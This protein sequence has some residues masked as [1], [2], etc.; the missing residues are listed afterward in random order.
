MAESCTQ[1]S[2]SLLIHI[3]HYTAFFFVYKYPRFLSRILT[4]LVSKMAYHEGKGGVDMDPRKLYVYALD[5][6]TKIVRQV[7]AEQMDLPTPD[8]EWTVHDLLQHITYELAWTADIVAGK[9][10]A[11]VGDKYEGELL[12]GNVLD[13]WEHYEAITRTAVE[14]CD[15]HGIAHL[16]YSDKTISEYLLEA[17]NDQLIH[18]WDLGQAIGVSVDFDEQ[19]AQTLYEQALARREELLES[20]LFKAPV[21]VE[22]SAITQTKL[23]AMLGRSENWN[24]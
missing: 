6:A 16:S 4:N 24:G 1:H 3:S 23:L 11:E 12:N 19:V 13:A 18:A 15:M 14:S 20:G 10:V 17:G 21:E 9:T 7:E 5:E 22:E 8:T 2:L